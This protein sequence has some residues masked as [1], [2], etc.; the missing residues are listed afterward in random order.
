MEKKRWM[1]C[2]LLCGVWSLGRGSVLVWGGITAQRR[3]ELV[4]INVFVNADPYETQVLEP[5]VR[6]FIQQHGGLLQQENARAHTARATQRYFQA[7]N[8]DVIDWPSLS[9]DLAPI[10]H[11]WD[12]LGRRVYRRNHPPR[13]VNELRQAL[14]EEWRGIPQ[15][16]IRNIVN[17]MRKRCTACIAA[18]GGHTRFWFWFRGYADEISAH[19]KYCTQLWHSKRLAYWQMNILMDL[20]EENI[21]LPWKPIKVL[22]CLGCAFF[23]LWVYIEIRQ[24]ITSK[25]S[26]LR[27]NIILHGYNA[28]SSSRPYD[29]GVVLSW[30][31][32]FL[33]VHNR[34]TYSYIMMFSSSGF[35]S[36]KLVALPNRAVVYH[37]N[38]ALVQTRKVLNSLFHAFGVF[39]SRRPPG[40]RPKQSESQGLLESGRTMTTEI[41]WNIST[42]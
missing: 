18:G 40:Y 5:V 29:E 22:Q 14:I 2:E 39:T 17:S 13:N 7:H 30:I 4:L 38:H 15:M 6:P 9:P 26:T 25:A 24:I 32:A 31:L 42:P 23:S 3:T 35:D 28:K 8:I 1:L 11:V 20:V 21:C 10:E 37:D 12:E 33:P 27:D 19:V 34:L 36:I 16:R 41:K